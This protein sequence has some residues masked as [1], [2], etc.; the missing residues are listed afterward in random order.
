[1]TIASSK[2]VTEGTL[3]EKEG[4]V[5]VC[6]YVPNTSFICFVSSEKLKGFLIIK[7]GIFYIFHKHFILY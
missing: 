4:V 1:M 3:A 2:P 5:M 6:Y 7:S